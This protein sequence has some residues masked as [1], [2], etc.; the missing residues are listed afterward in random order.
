MQR[1]HTIRI[2]L[3][4]TLSCLLLTGL[5]V[6]ANAGVDDVLLGVVGS[7]EMVD[8]SQ[9]DSTNFADTFTYNGQSTSSLT[10]GGNVEAQIGAIWTG[11]S[12]YEWREIRVVIDSNGDG[13]LTPFDWSDSSHPWNP[14]TENPSDGDS[15]TYTYP[16]DYPRTDLQDQ[17]ITITWDANCYCTDF[18]WEDWEHWWY[19]SDTDKTDNW[20]MES[21]QLMNV[22]WSGRDQNWNTLPN[23]NYKVQVWVDENGDGDFGETEAHKTMILRIETASITGT[24]V[25]S[26]GDPVIGARV[27]A[28]SHLA[29]GESRTES[30]GSFTVSGLEADADYHLRVQADGKVTYET[31]V[32]LASG[33][34]TA[35]AGTIEMSDAITITGTLKLDRNSN[36]ALDETEDQFEAFENQWGWEQ[37]DLWIWIDGHNIQGPGWGN[38]NVQFAVGDSSQDFSI[39]I[40][41]P[42]GN[43]TYQIN[44]HADGYV[45]TSNGN[46]LSSVS[47]PVDSTGGTAGTI[48]LTKAARLYG[49][50][51]LPA[52]V[53]DWNHIDVQAINE[54]NTDDRYWGWGNID[55]WREDGDGESE[56]TSVGEFAIDGIP[57]GTYR[58]EVRVMGYASNITENVEVVQGSDKDMGILE[59]SEGS[60]I[61]GTLTIQGDTTNLERW[62]GDSGD[63]LDVWIDAWSHSA[64]WSGTNVRVPR[65]ENQSVEFSLGGLDDATYEVNCWFG[66]G[67]ELV[68]SNGDSPV[69]VAVSGSTAAN[70]TLKPFEGIVQGVI[71]GTGIDGFDLSS[72]VVEVKRPWDWLPPKIAT[73]ANGGINGST[74]SYSVSGLGTGDYVVK[75]GAYTGFMSWDSEGSP[76]DLSGYQGDG[77]LIPDSSVGVSMDRS[78]VEN[79]DSNPTTLNIALERGYSISGTVTLSTTDAPWHDFGDGEGGDSNDRQDTTDPYDERISMEADVEGTAVMAMPM[80]MMF[81]GGEDPRM[82]MVQAN[83]AFT[84]DGLSPGAYM[85]MPPFSSERISQ[86]DTTTMQGHFFNGGEETHHWTATTQMVVITDDDVSSVNFEFANGYT[87][88]GQ[89]TLPEAQTYSESWEEWW[90]VG[91]LELETAQREFMGHGKPLMKRDFNQG[92]RYSFTFNHVANGDYL[93][94]F[95]TDRYVPGGS[96][97]TVSSTNTSVNLTIEEGANLVGKLVDADTGEAVTSADGIMVRCESVDHV[98]GS[99]RETRDDDW[100]QSYI[101]DG[102]DLMNSGSSGGG[103]GSDSEGARTNNTPG[104]FHLTALPTGHKYVVVVEASHG[105]KSNGA[106]NYVGRVIAGVEIPD[107]ATGDISVGTIKLTEGTTIQGRITDSSGNPIPGV[108]V[109]AMPSDTHDGSAEAEGMS[110]TQGYYTVYG[111]NPEVEYYDL[112]AAE[113]PDMFDDWGRKIEWGEKRKYNVAPETTDANFVLAPATATLSGTLT[114]PDDGV[115]QFMIPFKDEANNFPASIIMLQRKGVIYK[116]VMDG[117][118]VMSVP[119]PNGALTTTYVIDNLEPGTFKAIFMNYG[120]TTQVIDNVVVAD[121]ANTLN[122]TWTSAGYTVSGGLALASGGYPTT[123]DISGAICMNTNDQSLTFGNLTAEADGTYSAYEVPGLADG[124][125]YQLVFYSETGHD[126]P[127]DIFTVGEPFTVTE[128]ISGNTATISRE[129]VPVLMA[130]AIQNA[131]NANVIDIGIFSTSYLNDDS[132]EVV[133]TAPTT[134]TAGGEI[135]VSQGDGTLSTVILSGD[136]RN[137]SASYTKDSAD[138]TVILT[139][140]VHYGDDETTLLEQISFNVNTLAKNEDSVSVYIPGQVKLGN[141]DASQIYVPAGALDTSDDG[142]AIVS[143]EKTDEEPGTLSRES[144]A[145]AN[146]RG[147]FA[148]SARSALPDTA[149]AAGDQYDFSIA[150]ASD[151]AQVSQVNAVT[152]QVQYDPALVEDV[153]QLQIMHLVGETWTA[154][155]TNRTVDTENYTISADVDSLSPFI[156]AVVRDSDGGDDDSGDDGGSSSS[157]SSGGGGGGCFISASAGDFTGVIFLFGFCLIGLIIG[158]K[159]VMHAI[160][161]EFKKR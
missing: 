88:T 41:P 64:G 26:S 78:F 69:F 71:S 27:E 73:V 143:I 2:A 150:A 147:I 5:A 38:S 108:E 125:T 115:S 155:T 149:T 138:A 117:I 45:A 90:W 19:E 18:P 6:P 116:D 99:W 55:P 44:V 25:D 72:I 121:G 54:S 128:D 136:K 94:R 132:I 9:I 57:A 10:L 53:T 158:A 122:V 118:E 114:I 12:D 81:M 23:G 29:W 49:S 91:H 120:L 43:A 24:V 77:F 80:D 142:K 46:S 74:G 104:K 48:V 159:L 86:M 70:L 82:G 123:A 109:F 51:Q 137:L 95:W 15:W 1:P 30:D 63:S 21:G 100:S 148:R 28:G 61:T 145:V 4:I 85:I 105:Q 37:N 62:Y 22:W 107:G 153:D 60:K 93:V 87:V 76:S 160:T 7:Q 11:G 127:P 96:K 36:G 33:E 133:S 83:G 157:S 146:S 17:Q 47:I 42:D 126:G 161:V 66:E 58:L 20:W 59:I 75:A 129:T 34:T 144:R 139:L 156:P 14:P 152:V 151:S 79:D 98:E 68:D 52:A 101:E 40:P 103:D 65:G 16:S 141:G 113:R 3:A 131:D 134:E 39:N 106:K 56:S 140:A 8:F 124:Q 50:V 67:Y 112:I 35:S 89:L 119:A 84:I 154:E 13:N 97:F 130:Q 110:D 92:S 135:Y 32:T 31:N 102:E 111:I